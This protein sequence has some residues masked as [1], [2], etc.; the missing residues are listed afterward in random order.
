MILKNLYIIILL[1]FLS[2][3]VSKH[4]PDKLNGKFNVKKDLFLAQFDC[5]TDT[6][7]LYSVAGVATML[8]DHRLK[9]VRYHAVAGAYGI[10]EGLYIPADSLFEA[11]FGTHWSN[12][13][14]DYD[15]ALNEVTHLMMKT[16]NDSG[17][18]WIAEAGQSDFT[19]DCIRIIQKELP[20]V[21][22]SKRIHVVQ[23]SDWNENQTAP[24]NLTFVKANSDYHKIPD[25]NVTGNGSPGFYS[26]KKIN[27]LDYITNP[28][29]VKIWKLAIATANKYN[30]KDG[31]YKNPAIA[32]GGLDFSDAAETCWI[33]GFNHLA[34]ALA[35]FKTFSN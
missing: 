30:G 6:D 12:A 31:R 8:A 4:I 27:P 33:F 2:S 24:G 17:G 29:L 7:D 22:T 3:C 21:N 20:S 5:K 28:K 23:H 15:G 9:G 25:G 26:E 32:A 10:Q 16:L 14:S 1:S 19:A 35:F 11:A 34:D 18:I 13:H